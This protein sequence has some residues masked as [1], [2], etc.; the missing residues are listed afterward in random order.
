MYD[1]V[2]SETAVAVLAKQNTL[3]SASGS[4]SIS[5]HLVQN[6]RNLKQDVINERHMYAQPGLLQVKLPD[7]FRRWLYYTP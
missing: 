1:V 6:R 4:C 7:C 3:S 5:K 2:W